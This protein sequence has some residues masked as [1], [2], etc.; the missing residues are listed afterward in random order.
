MTRRPSGFLIGAVL[1]VGLLFS[2]NATA[3]DVVV[4][5]VQDVWPDTLVWGQAWLETI[6]EFEAT[7]PNIKI[8]RTYV[9]LGQNI[10]R[11]LLQTRTRSLPDIIAADVPDVPHLVEA[12]A[13]QDLSAF[14]DAWGQWDDVLPGSQG[15]VTWNDA[16]YAVQFSTNTIAL[17]YNKDLFEE[18][19]FT[20]PP[21]TWAELEEWAAKLTVPERGQ[22]GFAYSAIDTEEATWHF[23]PFLWS[24]GGD[25][26]ALDQPEAVEALEFYA[27]FVEKG[28]TSR[29]VVNWN[30]GDVGVQFRLGRAAMIVQGS[31]DIPLSV[32][33]DMNFGVAVIPPPE[34]GMPVIPPVG[35]E[36]FGISPFSPPER[37]QAAWTFLQWLMNRDG[38]TF[39]NERVGN[40]PT[41]ASIA[42]DVIAGNELLGP[43]LEELE[44]G[45]NR[46]S[47][48]GGTDYPNVSVATRKAIQ[49]VIVGQASAQEALRQAA[50]DIAELI[51]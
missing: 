15:A 20:R 45:R 32:A 40:I 29:E 44:N 16:P 3:Q 37:Q 11:I 47:Y 39:F 43:F 46:F 34:A 50:Q 17:H 1:A 49:A 23:L 31:W 9:P 21:E 5:S 19:G 14:I 12:G 10:Q 41:R 7:H 8:E 28:Y 38:M 25:L 33:E 48:G 2:A 26:L 22:Y 6:A 42:P 27:G 35:G 4:I 18:A 36:A 24:N 30:Q 51:D 13:L